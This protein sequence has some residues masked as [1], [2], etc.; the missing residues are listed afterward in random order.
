MPIRHSFANGMSSKVTIKRADRQL[1]KVALSKAKKALVQALSTVQSDAVANAPKNQGQLQNTIFF[2]IEEDGTKMLG[3]VFTDTEH[4]W[5]VE[6]GTG[7]VGAENHDGISP[8][9]PVAYK[10]KG[11][12]IPGSAISESDA[13]K[14]KFKKVTFKDGSIWWATNGQPAQPFLYPAFMN[15]ED[16]IDAIF[17]KALK[18]AMKEVSV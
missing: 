14:Y 11:W 7:P 5:Y 6:F 9:V 4:G 16:N 10:T 18:D 15:N 17:A 12:L 3:T 13:L 8:E 1:K 2:E